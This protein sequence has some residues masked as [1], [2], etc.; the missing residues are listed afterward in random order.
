MRVNRQQKEKENVKVSVK[1][2]KVIVSKGRDKREKE[3]R[4]KN[5]NVKDISWLCQNMEDETQGLNVQILIH[6]YWGK[7]DCLWI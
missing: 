7:N 2:L 3:L 6:S 1:R 4:K 5:G